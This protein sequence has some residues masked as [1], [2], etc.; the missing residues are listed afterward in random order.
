MKIPACMYYVYLP[1]GLY[2]ALTSEIGISDI[3]T[4]RRPYYDD[5]MMVPLYFT[6]NNIK[7]NNQRL[8]TVFY[9]TGESNLFWGKWKNSHFPLARAKEKS[10]FVFWKLKL[11]Y[12]SLP[13][14][15]FLKI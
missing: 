15:Y 8:I 4:E 12:G 5:V 10:L 6:V 3:C 11:N 7:C 9:V 1:S 14:F 13:T 2:S